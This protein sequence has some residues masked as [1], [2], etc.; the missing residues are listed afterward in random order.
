VIAENCGAS[1]SL[2]NSRDAT[3]P[4]DTGSPKLTPKRHT[5]LFAPNGNAT[6]SQPFS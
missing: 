2:P 6:T 3:N 1:W 4:T 5:M